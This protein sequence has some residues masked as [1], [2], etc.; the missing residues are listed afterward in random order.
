MAAAHQQ[1][2]TNIYIKKLMMSKQYGGHILFKYYIKGQGKKDVLQWSTH[3]VQ[4]KAAFKSNG[5]ICHTEKTT[6]K[7]EINN[8]IKIK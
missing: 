3:C 7:Q 8:T 5:Y 1:I 4:R 6:R 2:K